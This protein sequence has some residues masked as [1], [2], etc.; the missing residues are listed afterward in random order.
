VTDSGASGPAF[1]AREAPRESSGARVA[2][3]AVALV[4]AFAA[5]WWLRPTPPA[6]D[7]PRV[8]ELT[9]TGQ[10]YQPNV[11]PDGQFIAFTSARTGT[12]RIWLRQVE[13]GGEQPLTE[14]SDWRPRFAP[15]GQSLAFLRGGGAGYAA[16]RVSVLG[17]QARRLLDDVNEVAWAPDG[18]RLAF[19]RGTAATNQGIVGIADLETGQERIVANYGE[20]DLI[21]LDWSDDGRR[22][23]TTK[24]STQ[25]GSGNW[26]LVVIDV[27]GDDDP[28]E[29]RLGPTDLLSGPVWAGSD[30]LLF[31]RA[32][33][34][35][36][37]SPL[38]N[39]ILRV[40]LSS[41]EM[42][43][44]LYEP[45]LF[46]LRGAFTEAVRISLLGTDRIVFDTH[47]QLQTSSELD[48]RDGSLRT[49][50]RGVSTDRQPTYSPDGERIAFTSNRSGGVDLHAWH[51]DSGALL[52][53]TDHLA[54]DWDPA[55][56]PDGESLVWSSDRSGHLEI[57]MAAPDGSNPQRVTDDGFN[58]EN[59]T[60]T[61]DRA[62]I[63]YASGNADRPGIHRIR[64]DGTEVSLL[65][66]GLATNPEVS[67]DGRHAL[68]VIN[69]TGALYNSIRVVE[70]E[71][72]EVVDFS[73][74]VP[75]R[76][77]SPNVTYGRGRWMPGDQEIAF[78]GADGSGQATVFIQDFVPGQDTSATRRRVPGSEAA[79]VV[80]SFGISPD[81]TRFALSTIEVVR[82][83]KVADGLPPLR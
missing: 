34:T 22:L 19:T 52:Q 63:V 38:P 7:P 46:P 75:Y 44:L 3:V 81:G 62:W 43:S 36:S 18:D 78:I 77:E 28:T 71:T 66:P 76:P 27:E 10:D 82:V 72:G 58:A 55:F 25:G 50:A 70:I 56:T 31:A 32:P 14:G 11:S 61:P 16:Y 5:G 68:Y 65:V 21:G 42:R 39:E 60:M 30:A 40:D 33:S 57:W 53:L 79:G 67:H 17:G 80:E 9:F 59:P 37:A 6:L 69:N 1:A 20:W 64:P 23:A 12:S 74:H 13:G 54:S 24:A 83:L 73:I 29:I 35:V 15:D 8:S 41:G 45:Y 4:A 47:R 48:L 26:A 51:L 2:G 49:F